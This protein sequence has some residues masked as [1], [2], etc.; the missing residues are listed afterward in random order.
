MSSASLITRSI[1]G[2]AAVGGVLVIASC[3]TEAPPSADAAAAAASDYPVMIENCGAELAIES[4]PA[5][6]LT[7]GT[8]AIALLDV[9][10]ASDRITARAGEFG[11]ALPEGLE[12]EPNDAEIIDPSDPAIEAIVGAETDII[13]GYGLFNA[14]EDDVAAVGIPNIVIDGECSHD[15]ALTEKTDF[16]AIFADVERLADVFDTR[17]IADANLIELRAELDDLSSA[18]PTQPGEAAVVYYFSESASLSARGG[19]GIADD[20]LARAG[21]D[22]MSTATRTRYTLR[23]ISKRCSMPIRTRSCLPMDSTVRAS[24]RLVPPC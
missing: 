6:V 13:V 2:V 4:E 1:I 24:K 9:A 19:Q 21:F 7:V 5:S 22:W 11:A 17:D 16:D 14:S 20:V 8:S 12:H 18:S 23:R 15:A 10:G 3:S